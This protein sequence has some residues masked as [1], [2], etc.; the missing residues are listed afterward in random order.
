MASSEEQREE[1]GREI[2][3][4]D[5][6]DLEKLAEEVAEQLLRRPE[7]P[8]VL[9]ASYA[10]PLPPPSLYAGYEDVVPG[11]A[12]R[13]LTM[14]EEEGRNRR[15]LDRAFADYRRLGLWLAFAVTLAV[16]GAGTFLIYEDKSAYGLALILA[17]L[18]AVAGLFIVR[19]FRGNGTSGE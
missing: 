14:A 2:A 6:D 17:N 8:P 19:E 10:A 1:P 18:V 7:P 9:Y 4:L 5:P 13:I 11:A 16:I 15:L 12:D 3:R